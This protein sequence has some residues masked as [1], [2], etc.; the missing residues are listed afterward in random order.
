MRA[1]LQRGRLTVTLGGLGL[2]ALGLS[3]MLNPIGALAEGVALVGWILVIIGALTL[4][5]A[6]IQGRIPPRGRWVD[7]AVGVIELVPGIVLAAAAS[8]LTETV[9]CILGAYVLVAGVHTAIDA[10][11]PGVRVAGV[12]MGVL[13]AVVMGASLLNPV[14][15]MLAACLVL[16]VAG[17]VELV[18]SLRYVRGARQ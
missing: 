11:G 2:L 4:L 10:P 7:V 12:V 1:S 6:A 18:C 16:A 13:G 8:A 3:V 15:G 17:V 14:L 5:A 9:W